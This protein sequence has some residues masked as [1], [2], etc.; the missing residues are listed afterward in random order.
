MSKA[1][2]KINKP[3]VNETVEH[4]TKAIGEYDLCNHRLYLEEILKSYDVLEYYYLYR[5]HLPVFS[6]VGNKL[7]HGQDHTELVILNCYEGA[8]WEKLN[9]T[10]IRSL[11]VG[12]IFHDSRHSL[13]SD[14]DDQ[15]IKKAI[16]DLDF[17]HDSL[18]Q[19]AVKGIF[20]KVNV[21][22]DTELLLAKKCIRHTKYPYI[23]KGY[24]SPIE[25]NKP[26]MIIRDADLM[27]TYSNNNNTIIN[28]YVGL[29]R[30]TNYDLELHKL[31]IVDFIQRCSS[32]LSSVQWKSNW[33][34]RKAFDLNWPQNVKRVISLLTEN[35]SSYDTW[36]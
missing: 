34:K 12:A 26:L 18:S 6:A 32:F 21:L 27:N 10:T 7:Y 4:I 24:I 5:L 13:G 25:E 14:T 8:I 36:N 20:D 22:T 35:S 16:K 19:L 30:E 3:K 29:Y 15:N 11:L 33:A 1:N 31:P 23:K 28:L 17:K 2:R 9:R